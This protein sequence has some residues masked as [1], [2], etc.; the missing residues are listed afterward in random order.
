MHVAVS[1]PQGST[2]TGF[3]TDATTSRAI[4]GVR[5]QLI[6]GGSTQTDEHGAFGIG[7]TVGRALVEFSKNGYQTIEKDV[8]IS[9]DTQMLITLTP[10]TDTTGRK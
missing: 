4:V 7:V 2:L 1:R 8:T 6:G 3:V 10:L 5:V 9:G